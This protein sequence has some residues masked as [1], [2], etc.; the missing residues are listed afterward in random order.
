MFVFTNRKLL[1]ERNRGGQLYRGTGR[2]HSSRPVRRVETGTWKRLK[3]ADKK[4]QLFTGRKYRH[5]RQRT[6]SPRMQR[7][8]GR[9]HDHGTALRTRK[10]RRTSTTLERSV[11]DTN[12]L[13]SPPKT[14][15]LDTSSESDGVETPPRKVVAPR[16]A[17]LPDICETMSESD[18]PST[19][20]AVPTQTTQVPLK[21]PTP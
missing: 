1:C 11:P 13:L 19:P 16:Y 10:H 6:P 8:A 12:T 15:T 14:K 9:R 2:G 21:S 4:K 7:S 5:H 20:A 18:E 17:G 3:A